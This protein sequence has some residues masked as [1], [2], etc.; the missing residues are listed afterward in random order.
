MPYFSDW[1]KPGS[2]EITEEGRRRERA[3]AVKKEKR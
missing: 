1:H 3:K 2:Y